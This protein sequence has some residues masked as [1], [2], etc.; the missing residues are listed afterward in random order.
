ME[1]NEHDAVTPEDEEKTGCALWVARNPYGE[2][3]A[4]LMLYPD[5]PPEGVAE[6]QEIGGLAHSLGLMPLAEPSE[7]PFVATDTLC[8]ALQGALATLWAGDRQWLTLP[9]T[10][11]WTGRAIARRYIVLVIGTRIHHGNMD[12]QQIATYLSHREAIHLGLVRIRL[13]VEDPA[14]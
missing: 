1:A 10:D 5:G 9:V 3:S 6:N 7:I 12:S 11:E 8:V 4:Y 2:E 14:G 13:R